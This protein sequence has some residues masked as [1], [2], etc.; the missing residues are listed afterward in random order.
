MSMKD[1][2]FSISVEPETAREVEALH[3]LGFASASRA[4]LYREL[5]RLG[6]EEYHRQ[7]EKRRPGQ[8]GKEDDR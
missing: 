7:Q 5:I 2:R 6:L 1:K 3:R 4:R 8:A